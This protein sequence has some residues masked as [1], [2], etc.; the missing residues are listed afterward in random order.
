MFRARGWKIVSPDEAFEDSAY[1]VAPMIPRLDGSVLRT[2]AQALGVPL[3]PA[4]AGLRSERR[5][6][7]EADRLAIQR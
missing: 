2:T 4:L 5:V 6:G 1:Q 7:E 3:Q